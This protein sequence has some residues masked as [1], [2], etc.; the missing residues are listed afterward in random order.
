MQLD[1]VAIIVHDI[2]QSVNWYQSQFAAKIL[3]QDQSWAFL[4]MGS[5]KLALVLPGK[6]PSHI[7][8]AVTSEELEMRAAQAGKAI[9][10][11]IQIGKPRRKGW[12]AD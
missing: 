5:T 1:H 6:H 12:Q 8:V 7:A 2:S 11:E 3:Y 4:Q 9:E 10:S